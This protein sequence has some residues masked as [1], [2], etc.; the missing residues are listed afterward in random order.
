MKK[1]TET[2]EDQIEYSVA[3]I[4]YDVVVTEE[5]KAST[6]QN[7]LPLLPLSLY[8]QIT[9]WLT[10]VTETHDTEGVCSLTVVD[11]EWKVIVWH[12]D[13]PC[14]LHVDFDESLD[15]NQ[16]LIDDATRN[17]LKKVHC[18]IHSHNKAPASQSSNDE[19]DEKTKPGWHIT[20]GNCNSKKYTT[21][22]RFNINK[23][24]EYGTEPENLGKKVAKAHQEF[25]NVDLDVII[26]AVDSDIDPRYVLSINDIAKLP[27]ESD[28][29]E[30]W[31]DRV[32]VQKPV[33]NKHTTSYGSNSY[34]LMQDPY[35]YHGKKKEIDGDKYFSSY[36][37]TRNLK[38]Q[39][40]QSIYEISKESKK[41]V[42][43]CLELSSIDDKGLLKICAKA[44]KQALQLVSKQINIS[45]KE[46]SKKIPNVN[47]LVS[48]MIDLEYSEASTAN[49]YN[50]VDSRDDKE[51]IQNLHESLTTNR[52]A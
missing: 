19:K 5:Y 9:S 28:Y 45:M 24:A 21:H 22:A 6:I 13:A 11:N 33:Y 7:K 50:Y 39:L 37:N 51:I 14:S 8:Q 35:H 43:D 48:L 44:R 42:A 36:L 4:T 25:I 38:W 1:T 18:T 49:V 16:G 40:C 29:P 26:E 30:E 52:V 17:A 32:T 23:D 20:V 3:D 34:G 31:L 12:Q 47:N 27:M 46:L 2:F 15:Q 10:D 41:K